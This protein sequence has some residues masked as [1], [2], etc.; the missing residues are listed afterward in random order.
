MSQLALECAGRIG[1]RRPGRLPDAHMDNIAPPSPPALIPT[2]VPQ[3]TPTAPAPQAGTVA[4][5]LRVT[6]NGN[7]YIGRRVPP[8]RIP[9]RTVRARRNLAMTYLENQAECQLSLK[10]GS[11]LRPDEIRQLARLVAEQTMRQ[12]PVGAPV[13]LEL[14]ILL[15]ESAPGP[16]IRFSVMAMALDASR[17]S[18]IPAALATPNNSTARPPDGTRHRAVVAAT[19]SSLRLGRLPAPLPAMATVDAPVFPA[20]PGCAPAPSH[21]PR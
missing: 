17:N 16:R 11:R 2:V 7:F 21:P 4:G 19:A 14:R 15:R 18:S 10:L 1:E 8:P 6:S 5:T 20:P 12:V 9:G 3:H 13:P